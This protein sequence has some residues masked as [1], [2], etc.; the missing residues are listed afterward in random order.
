MRPFKQMR[1]IYLITVPIIA[2]LM[3]LLPQS[4]GDR[5]LAFFWILIF[6]GLAVGFTYLMEFI[7]RRLKGK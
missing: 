7:G 4:L 5:I 3:F 6:G 2:I 1:I